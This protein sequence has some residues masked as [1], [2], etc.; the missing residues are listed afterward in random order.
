MLVVMS[1]STKRMPAVDPARVEVQWPMS[2]GPPAT[3]VLGTYSFGLVKHDESGLT[4]VLLRPKV[5]T[6]QILGH[7]TPS[8]GVPPQPS[9]QHR[10][11][12]E[13]SRGNR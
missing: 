13:R 10:G 6:D 1:P 2:E 7:R 11:Q 3:C 4:T 8:S 12:F 9:L 5:V